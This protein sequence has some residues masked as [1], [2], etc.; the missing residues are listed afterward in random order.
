MNL[1][2]VYAEASERLG[3]DKSVVKKSYKLFWKF[4]RNK[5]EELP[6]KEDLT[7]EE[8][9]KLRT[10][11]NVP[12]VGK[13]YCTYKE[14]SGAHKKHEFIKKYKKENEHKRNKTI[15]HKDCDYN[16]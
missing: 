13:L 9:R 10:N 16:G 7:E 8:F 2:Q 5:I 1:E 6:L 14:F 11:F 15:V 3:I 4:I 12:S